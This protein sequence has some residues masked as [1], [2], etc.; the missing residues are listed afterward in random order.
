MSSSARRVDLVD[1]DDLGHGRG[2]DLAEHLADG[3]DLALRVGVGPVDDVQQQVGGGDLLQRR[4]ERLDQLVRQVPDEADGVGER[5]LPA[6]GRLRAP[7]RRVEGREQRVLHEHA[8]AG[9]PVEQAGL[10][11]VGVA[12]DRHAGDGVAIAAGPLGGAGR[13]HAGDLPAQLA[14]PRPDPPP[15]GLDLGLTGTTGTDA[16]TAGDAATRLAGHR[17]TPAAQARAACTA[18]GRARPGPC[19]PGSWRAGRR[20]RGSARSGRRP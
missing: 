5:V 3:V 17:L 13:L 7:D 12:G 11:G 9:Q 8:G 16:A 2:V 14:H 4:A 18:S 15:V 19:P 20:C 6:V 1:D 10:A